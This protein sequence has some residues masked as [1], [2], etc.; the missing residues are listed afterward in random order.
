MK[1][2]SVSGDWAFWYKAGRSICGRGICLLRF[3][4]VTAVKATGSGV[5]LALL[6]TTSASAQ[7]SSCDALRA[8]GPDGAKVFVGPT[9]SI[10]RGRV[11]TFLAGKGAAD[12]RAQA[13]KALSLTDDELADLSKHSAGHSFENFEPNCEWTQDAPNTF[14][15]SSSTPAFTFTNPLFSSDGNLALIARSRF[16]GPGHGRG[17]FCAIRRTAEGWKAVCFNGWIS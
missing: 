15:P 11:Q 4:G 13:V 16:D 17:A 6:L 7:N 1:S 10:D 9:A 14:R 8:A 2:W 5:V 12:Y 3:E